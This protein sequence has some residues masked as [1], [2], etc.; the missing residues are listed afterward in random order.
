MF[1]KTFGCACFPHLRPYSNHKFD[2]HSNKCIF[3]G[4]SNDH[5]GYKCLHPTGRVYIAKHVTFNELDFP[6][7]PKN[8]HHHSTAPTS[9]NTVVNITINKDDWGLGSNSMDNSALDHSL[10]SNQP[11]LNFRAT[12]NIS[13][14]DTPPNTSPNSQNTISE[15]RGINSPVSE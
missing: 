4:Y 14:P 10:N 3:L 7:Q 13:K 5:K 12:P 2:F 1:T 15:P 11:Q 6:Y 8:T 9:P